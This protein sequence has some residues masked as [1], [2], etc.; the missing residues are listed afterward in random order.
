MKSQR[1]K[2]SVY[3]GWITAE[4]EGPFKSEPGSEGR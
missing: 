3:G 4:I 1:A 2:E